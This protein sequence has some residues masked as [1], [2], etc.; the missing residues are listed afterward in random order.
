MGRIGAN[1]GRYK[2]AADSHQRLKREKLASAFA[3]ELFGRARFLLLSL[4]CLLCGGRVVLLLV[5]G[6]GLRL[7][8]R[9]LLVR[10]LRRFVTHDPIT[11]AHDKRRQRELRRIFIQNENA[12]EL[13]LTTAGTPSSSPQKTASWGSPRPE[14]VG[15]GSLPV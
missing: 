8:L 10:G 5:R 11:K 13:E 9:R 6:G 3:R 4:R 1:R 12:D 15:I 14:R 7:F 2:V